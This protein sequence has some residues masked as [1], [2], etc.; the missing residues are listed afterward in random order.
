MRWGR[1]TNLWFID[2]STIFYKCWEVV[3]SKHTFHSLPKESTSIDVKR[4]PNV[5]Q[6]IHLRFE[7]SKQQATKS[8]PP[9]RLSHRVSTYQWMSQTLFW[10]HPVLVPTSDW[11]ENSSAQRCGGSEFYQAVDVWRMTTMGDPVVV[12]IKLGFLPRGLQV[13]DI[14]TLR[15]AILKEI[16]LLYLQ[17]LI[18]FKTLFLSVFGG[19]WKQENSREVQ[20]WNHDWTTRKIMK[21]LHIIYIY[22]IIYKHANITKR[23]L[24]PWRPDD[25]WSPGAM[26]TPP[27]EITR[28]PWMAYICDHSFM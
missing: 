12:V 26:A 8:W 19:H 21:H 9:S 5:I 3:F 25:S 2:A 15:Q 27:E 7:S 16:Y 4:F 14:H 17:W 1:N 6:L 20:D 28:P 24:L 23:P 11:S 22:T 10:D 13:V 18:L